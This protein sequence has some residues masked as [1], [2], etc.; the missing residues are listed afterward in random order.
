MFRLFLGLVVFQG[1]YAKSGK[2]IIQDVRYFISYVI[3]DA[4]ADNFFL[5]MKNKAGYT[6]NTSCG[7]VGRGGNARFHTFQLDHHDGPTNQP[8]DGQSLL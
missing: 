2:E 4:A 7:R 5:Q 3:D 1:P 6:A 8:T